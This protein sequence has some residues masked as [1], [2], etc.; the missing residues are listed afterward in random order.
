MPAACTWH[1]ASTPVSFHDWGQAAI[2][3]LNRE[4]G[5]PV[6]DAGLFTVQVRP[7][8]SV[9]DVVP[10]ACAV[11]TGFATAVPPMPLRT[12]MAAIVP[13]NR[14][15]PVTSAPTRTSEVELKTEVVPAAVT[16]GEPC[17]VHGPAM[18][19]AV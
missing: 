4:I 15:L 2:S 17:T 7:A 19:G 16:I 14:S 3:P 6:S 8:L 13:V 1:H 5:S 10:D 11:N 12:S 9:N 18:V